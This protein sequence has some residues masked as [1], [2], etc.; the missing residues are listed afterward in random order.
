MK[1]VVCCGL[2]A[3]SLAAPALAAT[4]PSKSACAVAW[5]RSATAMLRRSIAAQ[6]PKG[7]FID[8]AVVG[9]FDWSAGGRMHS[10]SGAGC[11]IQFILRTGRTLSVSG[12]WDGSRVAN[13]SRPVASPRPIPV[14]DNSFVRADGTVAF[15]G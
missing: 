5:N 10:S 14:P 7:A 6:H 11:G 1:V 13:W 3:A 2:V 12:R 15:H 9:T 4:Q 8:A